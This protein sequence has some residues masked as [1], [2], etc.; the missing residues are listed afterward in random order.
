MWK[1]ANCSPSRSSGETSAANRIAQPGR[2]QR[3][4]APAGG[5]RAALAARGAPA[6][7]VDDGVG[8]QREQHDRRANVHEVSTGTSGIVTVARSCR[9][10]GRRTAAGWG[11]GEAGAIELPPTVLPQWCHSPTSPGRFADPQRRILP[12]GSDPIQ[13]DVEIRRAAGVRSL[14]TQPAVDVR[15]NLTASACSSPQRPPA[16]ARDK[17]PRAGVERRSRGVDVV[18]QQARGG[19]ACRS[20][21]ASRPLRRRCARLEPTWRPARSRRRRQRRAGRPSRGASASAR[22]P[23]GSNPAPAF[24]RAAC[25]GTGT[26]AAGA[27]ASWSPGRFAAMCAAIRVGHGQRA[28]ELQRGDQLARHAVV[29]ERRPRAR[30]RRAGGRAAAAVRG[31]PQRGQPRAGQPRQC[32]C[33]RRAQ[34]QRR[35]WQGGAAGRRMRV[36]R[37]RR[38]ARRGRGM[39]RRRPCRARCDGS[40]R[41]RDEP[42][43]KL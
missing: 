5:A 35:P 3:R 10:A 11:S 37:R 14:P 38:A 29:R 22:T 19:G 20:S 6:Q 41:D 16:P 28:A 24:A 32:L 36:G 1:V 13:D 39:A 2:P 18:D 26:S 34:P 7:A 4:P 15:P 8:R 30:E 12:W 9:A 23:A 33:A 25:A 21:I 31:R 27:P 40:T 42:A 17:R 43:P